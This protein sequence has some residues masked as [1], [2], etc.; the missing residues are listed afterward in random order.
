M[1]DDKTIVQV[2]GARCVPSFALQ[3]PFGNPVWNVCGYEANRVPGLI[4]YAS[5]W[6]D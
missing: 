5:E 6:N 3:N 1:S 4:L 2:G